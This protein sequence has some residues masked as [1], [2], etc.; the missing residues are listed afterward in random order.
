MSRILTRVAAAFSTFVVAL[1]LSTHYNPL[2]PNISPGDRDSFPI[3]IAKTE[4]PVGSRLIAEQLQLTQMPRVIADGT[5]SKIDNAIIGRVAV[6]KIGAREPIT[7]SRLAPVGS[8]A[9]LWV[10]P[11]GYRAMTV[12]VDDVVGTSGFIQ[13]NTLVDVFVMIEPSD[14]SE[15]KEHVSKIVLQN[16]KVLANGKK[17]E[18]IKNGKQTASVNTM[19]L[20]ITP[21]QAEKLALAAN[22]GKLQAVVRS[23]LY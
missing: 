9:G 13:P 12:R 2:G 16:I 7:E 1:I 15:Q 20:Q 8:A 4:I 14:S 23:S 3:L 18:T 5:F 17:I 6:T 10:I 21:D 22:E 19:T 11:E